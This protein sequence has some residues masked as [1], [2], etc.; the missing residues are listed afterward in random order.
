M[1]PPLRFSL[2]VLPVEQQH[3]QPWKRPSYS[4]LEV[5]IDVAHGH[6]SIISLERVLSIFFHLKEWEVFV[7]NFYV[8]ENIKF[9]SY[10][11]LS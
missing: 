3:K 5:R 8:L 2:S 6:I 9:K 7:L 1:N 11:Q 10:V 4:Q